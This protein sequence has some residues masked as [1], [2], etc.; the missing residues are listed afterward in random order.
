MV[1]S[2]A[3]SDRARRVTVQMYVMIC[4]YDRPV[5]TSG[6]GASAVLT[7]APRLGTA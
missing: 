7:L 1:M 3:A 2:F 4:M 6:P 5:C